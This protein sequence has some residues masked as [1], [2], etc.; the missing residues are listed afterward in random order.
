MEGKWWVHNAFKCYSLWHTLYFTLPFYI[1]YL[2]IH[3]L[4]ERANN[5][6]GGGNKGKLNLTLVKQVKSTIL[7]CSSCYNRLP[8][9]DGLINNGNLFLIVLEVGSPRSMHWDIHMSP[10]PST[11]MSHCILTWQKGGGNFLGCL[12]QWY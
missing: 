9:T 4:K 6:V 3:F 7:V 12:L 11:L 10:L 1:S 5:F 2:K 8:Y